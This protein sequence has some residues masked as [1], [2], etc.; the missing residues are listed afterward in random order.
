M[1]LSIRALC[2]GALLSPYTY[3]SIQLTPSPSKLRRLPSEGR[4]GCGLGEAAAA[5]W[6]QATIFVHA[7]SCSL[8]PALAALLLL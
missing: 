7:L 1:A 2:T 6:P 4:A 8:M 3:H 5:S